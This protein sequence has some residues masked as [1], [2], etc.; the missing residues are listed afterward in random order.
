MNGFQKFREEFVKS[1][2]GKK[3]MFILTFPIRILYRIL[4]FLVS[5]SG[6]I[7]YIYSC[8]DCC[9]SGICEDYANV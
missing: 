6:V 8:R 9:R 5:F 1:S 3:A 2:A 4:A 7:N